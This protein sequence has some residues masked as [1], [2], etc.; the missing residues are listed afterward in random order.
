VLATKGASPDGTLITTDNSM[1]WT[2]K[3]VEKADVYWDLIMMF[4]MNA[5]QLP[6]STVWFSVAPTQI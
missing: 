3:E 5:A 4:T 1:H 6:P 2:D